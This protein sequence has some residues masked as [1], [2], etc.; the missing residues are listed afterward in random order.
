M[1]LWAQWAHKEL[2]HD[3]M[4]NIPEKYRYEWNKPIWGLHESHH[5][6]RE[7]MFEGNDIFAIINAAPA[8]ALCAYGKN[9]LTLLVVNVTN[10]AKH[11]SFASC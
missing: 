6:P 1:E 8:I 11:G 7:A 9:R 5:E 3:W 2:W 4:W 10:L